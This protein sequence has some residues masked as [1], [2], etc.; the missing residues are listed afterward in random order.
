MGGKKSRE[1]GKRGERELAN[2]LSQLGIESHRG[3][4]YRGSPESPDVVTD[5]EG[6]HI[7]CKR[8]ERFNLYEALIQ[9]K[10]DAGNGV[11]VV[12]HRKNRE[13]WVVVVELDN[14]LALCKLINDR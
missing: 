11:P 5:I 3:Q 1:K 6:L 7:E 14:L 2:R 10:N 13:P 12:A 9:A 8:V 4:Q